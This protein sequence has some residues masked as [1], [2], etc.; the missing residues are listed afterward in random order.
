MYYISVYNPEENHIGWI[1][2]NGNLTSIREERSGFSSKETADELRSQLEADHNDWY[3]EL[4][5]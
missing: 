3:T 5:E 4:E 2:S 1:D